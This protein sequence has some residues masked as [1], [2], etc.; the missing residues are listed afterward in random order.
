MPFGLC[1]ASAIFDRF[2]ELVMRGPICKTCLIYLDGVKV[3]GRTFMGA[4]VGPEYFLFL[5]EISFLH[6]SVSSKSVDT[7][8]SSCCVELGKTDQ[9]G[10][11]RRRFYRSFV[12]GFVDTPK[13]L[14]RLMEDKS[15]VYVVRSVKSL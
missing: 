11:A 3:V 4:H 1:N 12:E 7:T 6:H 15:L 2:M 5:Q 14:R 9:Q 10:W 13:P 8:G